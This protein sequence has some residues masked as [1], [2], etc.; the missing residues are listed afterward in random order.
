LP[1]RT[2]VAIGPRPSACAGSSGNDEV[3]QER[4]DAPAQAIGRAT[5]PSTSTT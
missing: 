2:A 4:L 3:A 5:S 1:V